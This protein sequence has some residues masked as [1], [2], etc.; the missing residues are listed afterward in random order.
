MWRRFLTPTWL[1]FHTLV[2]VGVVVMTWL[3]FW[4][5]NRLDDRQ[6]FNATVIT[7]TEQPPRDVTSVLQS[8]DTGVDLEWTPVTLEGRWLPDHQVLVINRSQ[9]GVAGRNVV[10][11]VQLSDGTVI[12][13]TRGFVS[14]TQQP[15]PVPGDAVRLRGLLRP[16]E[17][18]S[19][20]GVSDPSTGRLAELQRLDLERLRTQLPPD[21]APRLALWSV[22]LEGS[23]PPQPAPLVPVP[24]PTLSEGTHLSYA[25]QWFV[26]AL[27]AVVGWVFAMRR[28]IMSRRA[29]RRAPDPSDELASA[30]NV[31][32]RAGVGTPPSSPG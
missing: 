9:G 6:A 4:Q 16:S 10:T 18:R 27:C 30:S 8:A 17:Q 7:R 28:S 29:A 20:G 5:L 31:A 26:F 1:G 19:F 3:G 2:V 22:S 32:A 14:L 24:R 13:V 15:P 11:P 23:D 12:A 25:V 21:V